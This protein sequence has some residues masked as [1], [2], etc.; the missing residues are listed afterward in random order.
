MKCANEN[1]FS[2]NTTELPS[3]FYFLKVETGTKVLVQKVLKQ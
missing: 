3:G 2:I 1:E